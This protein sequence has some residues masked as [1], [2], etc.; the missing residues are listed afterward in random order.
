MRET[1]LAQKS[2]ARAINANRFQVLLMRS[3]NAMLFEAREC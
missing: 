3:V 1:G 2:I